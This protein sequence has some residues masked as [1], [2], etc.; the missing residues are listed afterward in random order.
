MHV[1]MKFQKFSK[2]SLDFIVP[3]N[4]IAPSLTPRPTSRKARTGLFFAWKGGAD[5]R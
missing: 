1:T 3:M 2:S 4:I 5:A